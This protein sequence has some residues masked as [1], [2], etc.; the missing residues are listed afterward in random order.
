MKS[1]ENK[2]KQ[3]ETYRQIYQNQNL[4]YV[5]SLNIQPFKTDNLWKIV[6]STNSIIDESDPDNDLPQ[7]YHA[8]QTAESL[9]KLLNADGS[10]KRI[11][12]RG[13]LGVDCHLNYDYLHEMYPH[14]KTWDWLP[15]TGFLHDIGKILL[16]PEY[17]E[18]PQW[19]VT[20][21][22]FPVGCKISKACILPSLHRLNKDHQQFDKL[23]IYEENCGFENLIMSFG[24][25]E[26]LAKTL[27]ESE[28]CS[29]P[30]EA[31]YLIRFH[32]FYPW[33]SP[34]K[35]VENIPL[36][37]GYMHF[38]SKKDWKMLPLL[39]AFHQSDLYSKERKIPDIGKLEPYYRRLIGKY[40]G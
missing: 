18:Y 2:P 39:K 31:I 23:G 14:I 37:R 33:H 5:R 40:F 26:Y 16:L 25:D 28:N 6:E 30:E 32:S 19:S 12:I 11:N 21:D 36:V 22:T 20:G 8:Y 34:E 38:A 1:Y 13:T 29:L 9:R 17:G 3:I 4:E 7:I 27:E 35:N 10:L 15:L 24:H